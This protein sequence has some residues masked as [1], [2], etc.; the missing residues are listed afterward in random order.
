MAAFLPTIVNINPRSLYNKVDE[1]CTLV[2]MESVDVVLVSE[3]WERE[4]LPLKEVIKLENFEIVSD[5]HQRKG[6]GGRSA[7][8]INKDKFT[9]KNLTNTDI[10]IP[11]G[12]ETV[13]ALLTPSNLPLNSSVKK[14]ACCAVS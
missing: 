1:F 10:Q 6:K 14:I 2:K 9:V 8:M 13:W 11:W 7:I 3:T 12:V 5:V 4:E